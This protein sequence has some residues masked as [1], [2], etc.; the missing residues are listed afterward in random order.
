MHTKKPFTR[1]DFNMFYSILSAGKR[2]RERERER[3]R[4]LE[5][6]LYTLR[7]SITHSHIFS[8]RINIIEWIYQITFIVELLFQKL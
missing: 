4:D 5:I 1:D 8:R 6:F 7:Q 2:E 3:E